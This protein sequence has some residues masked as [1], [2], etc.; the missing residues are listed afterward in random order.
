M[1]CLLVCLLV[2]SASTRLLAAADAFP[3]PSSL[4]DDEGDTGNTSEDT[5]KIELI[6]LMIIYVIVFLMMLVR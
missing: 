5:L 2:A 4:A 6:F 3:A 1:R